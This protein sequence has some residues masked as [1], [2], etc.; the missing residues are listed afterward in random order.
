MKRKML[1]V[2]CLFIAV[3]ALGTFDGIQPARAQ[4]WYMS[5]AGKLQHNAYTLFCDGFTETETLWSEIGSSPYLRDV[6]TANYIA[7]MRSQ[8]LRNESYFT[9]DD[10]GVWAS[11]LDNA[12]LYFYAKVDGFEDS[13]DV[14]G[15]IEPARDRLG[16]VFVESSSYAWYS[17]D[18]SDCFSEAT[19]SSINGYI[20]D[21]R[22]A[23][24]CGGIGPMRTQESG[25]TPLTSSVIYV[26]CVQL[27]VWVNVMDGQVWQE[28][29]AAAGWGKLNHIN[30]DYEFFGDTR[31]WTGFGIKDPIFSNL[32][33]VGLYCIYDWNSIIEEFGAFF[34]YIDH[35]GDAVSVLFAFDPGDMGKYFFF[36]VKET[37]PKVW[38]GGVQLQDG[39][40]HWFD[41][42]TYMYH[43][44][45][46]WKSS[47]ESI[48]QPS[49]GQSGSIV[50]AW[51]DIS[52]RDTND[53][54]SSGAIDYRVNGAGYYCH[55][56][57]PV[58]DKPSNSWFS[59]VQD[60]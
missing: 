25:M 54:W 6:D 28:T 55:A 47:I 24:V 31:Y 39:S 9:F 57:Y 49:S 5:Y 48:Y 18:V 58:P 36:M 41:S 30:F 45:G 42:H 8:L 1:L 56:A 52:T 37:S 53:V 29:T 60:N 35:G 7:T 59:F 21:F 46:I 27:Y 33:E 50:C 43:W 26:T 38:Q 19:P 34:T 3:M 11:G 44:M 51:Y 13:F 2:S 20:S 40:W 14:Y 12:T 32:A 10:L 23:L 4:E 17:L 16:I 15:G 22:I